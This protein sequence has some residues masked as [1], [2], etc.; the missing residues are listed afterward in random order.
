MSNATKFRRFFQ[1]WL[2][3]PQPPFRQFTY[4][5]FYRT[6]NIPLPE[7]VIEVLEMLEGKRIKKRWLR[8]PQPPFRRF[9]YYNIYRTSDTV[10]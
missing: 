9:V 3:V 10:A 6:T 7:V 1:Q 5:N 8:V 4:Y 2:R